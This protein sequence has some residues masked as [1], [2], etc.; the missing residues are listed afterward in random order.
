MK[1]SWNKKEVPET[2]KGSSKCTYFGK[3]NRFS[4]RR[5]E[6]TKLQSRAISVCFLHYDMEPEFSP[7]NSI[8]VNLLKALPEF[9]KLPEYNHGSFKNPNEIQNNAVGP[10]LDQCWQVRWYPNSVPKQPNS[11]KFRQRNLG[12]WREK[13]AKF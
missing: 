2:S 8:W 10:L 7:G 9:P 11:R 5:P 4:P 6:N 13:K 1:G 12:K 3:D